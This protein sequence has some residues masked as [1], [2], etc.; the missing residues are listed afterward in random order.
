M[1]GSDKGGDQVG[2]QFMVDALARSSYDSPEEGKP[3]R[4]VSSA[5]VKSWGID[6]SS[7]KKT[8]SCAWQ[9]GCRSVSYWL[10]RMLSSNRMLQISV[11]GAAVGGSVYL[12]LK[13]M[14]C[15]EENTGFESQ[16]SNITL[17]ERSQLGNL[18][19]FTKDLAQSEHRLDCLG[20]DL[21]KFSEFAGWSLIAISI[22]NLLRSL[23]RITRGI[24]LTRTDNFKLALTNA[25][26]IS[27]AAA[28]TARGCCKLRASTSDDSNIKVR[29]DPY[30]SLM[31]CSVISLG[32]LLLMLKNSLFDAS[33]DLSVSQALDVTKDEPPVIDNGKIIINHVLR[34]LALLFSNESDDLNRLITFGL[35]FVF[36]ISVLK[37]LDQIVSPILEYNDNVKKL[38][39]RR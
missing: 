10:C 27:K 33:S 2:T 9:E 29:A 36:V 25:S 22:P 24:S 11:Y 4:P 26:C 12:L 15:V 1:A 8:F 18:F 39:I 38:F 20:L 5:Y 23:Y 13:N 16:F 3:T 31:L 32:G 7:R 21:L 35:I 6:P 28:V 34:A 17:E 14:N 19:N 30:C 37:L